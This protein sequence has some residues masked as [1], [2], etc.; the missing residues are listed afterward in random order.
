[1]TTQGLALFT[2]NVYLKQTPHIV[3]TLLNM[4]LLLKSEARGEVGEGWGG[5]SI[6][7]L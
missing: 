6:V 5:W 3:L 1:M 4:L 7:T 2:S